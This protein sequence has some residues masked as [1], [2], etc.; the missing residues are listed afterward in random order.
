MNNSTVVKY[1]TVEVAII[2]I[3]EIARSVPDERACTLVNLSDPAKGKIFLW[4]WIE[5]I[6]M[7]LE[8]I[9]TGEKKNNHAN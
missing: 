7:I 1:N 6:P 4:M 8:F 9:T 3:V 2:A 5:R